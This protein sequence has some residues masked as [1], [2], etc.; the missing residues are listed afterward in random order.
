MDKF[1]IRFDTSEE[2]IPQSWKDNPVPR[3]TPKRPVGRP[4]KKTEDEN[5]PSPKRQK[6]D[7]DLRCQDSPDPLAKGDIRGHYKSFSL[8]EK[9]EVVEYARLHGQRVAAREF[10]VPKSTVSDW[11][12]IEFQKDSRTKKGHLHRPGRPVSYG[13]T[14]DVKLA[15]WVLEQRDQQLP[16]SIDDI[17]NQAR[18]LVD[19]EN[20]AASRNWADH[21]MKRHDLVLRAKTSVAQR[22][23][24]DLE[25]KIEAFLQYVKQ[26]REEDEFEDQFIINM[27]ETPMYFDLLPG[28]TVDVKG[29][30]SIRIRTTGSEKRHLT[31]VLAV[32]AAGDVLPPMIIFKGKRPVSLNVPKGW[33]VCVQEKAWMDETLM[34]RWVKE[35]LFPH[36]KKERCLLVMD[37]FRAHLTE[38]VKKTLRKGNTV[39]AIIPGG[40]TSKVQPLDVSLNKPFKVDLRKSWSSFIRSATEKMREEAEP[41]ERLKAADKATVLSWIVDAVSSLKEKKEIVQKSFKVCGITNNM[42]GSEDSLIRSDS[43]LC[44]D[45]PADD[46]PTANYDS[47]DEEE[48]EGFSAGDLEEA[49]LNLRALDA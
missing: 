1:V 7:K 32:S 23:P 11:T 44:S 48:F 39:T 2:A 35:I 46:V 15:E 17:C 22:L 24:A 34:I 25:K 16:V 45:S 6:L 47:D 31:V 13:T 20:F 3:S 41:T 29:R 30:K 19:S 49:M 10:K 42:N 9:M 18:V 40:C 12:K 27:D 28:K 43:V 4:K 26:K 5:V 33:I 21:F 37:S 36:T 14:T 38:D 8:K